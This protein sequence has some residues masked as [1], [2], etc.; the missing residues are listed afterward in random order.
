MPEISGISIN[1][2]N[3]V[4]GVANRD[5]GNEEELINLGKISSDATNAIDELPA[6][7]P[8]EQEGSRELLERLEKM[9]EADENLKPQNKATA[10]EQ[11][12]ALAEAANNPEVEE[13]K[14]TARSAIGM[15]RGMMAEVPKANNFSEACNTLLPHIATIFGLG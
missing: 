6:S 1:T 14:N 2:Q 7:P 3:D 9:I 15:L 4:T 10:L 12:K 5:L 8:P 11:V 13:K